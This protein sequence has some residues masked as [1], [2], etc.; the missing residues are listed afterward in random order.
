MKDLLLSA[1]VL[2]QE[3][4]GGEEDSGSELIQVVPG[5]MIWT[6]VVFLVTFWILKKVAFGRIQGLIEQR[7]D[8]IAE[9]LDEADNARAEARSLLDEHKALIADARTQADQVLAEA[10]K[11]GDA[12]RE[13]VKAEASADLERRLDENTKSIEAENRKLLEQVRREVVELTLIAS[14]K[15]TGKTLDADDQRRL[16]DEAVE[17]LDFDRIARSN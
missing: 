17:E 7:R 9:A 16:I 8:R 10:R 13:R 1:I 3:S 6:A 5:L 11:Q 2:A 15:V 4:T 14:E 12:Q